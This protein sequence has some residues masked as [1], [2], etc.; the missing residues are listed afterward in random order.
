MQKHLVDFAI[1]FKKALFVVR[2]LPESSNEYNSFVKA[3]AFT[4]TR[5]ELLT[6]YEWVKREDE[7]HRPNW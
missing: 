5:Y 2:F 7:T 4:R 1:D 6:Y 3:R